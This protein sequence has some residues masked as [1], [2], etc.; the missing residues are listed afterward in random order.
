VREVDLD[1]GSFATLIYSADFQ[2][3]TSARGEEGIEP[4][5]GILITPAGDPANYGGDESL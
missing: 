1:Y 5:K 2:G 3:F 4:L